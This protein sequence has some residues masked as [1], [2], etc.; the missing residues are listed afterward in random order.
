MLLLDDGKVCW[1]ATDLTRAV[2]CEYALVRGIDVRY[3][4][5]ETVSAP[6]LSQGHLARLGDLHEKQVLSKYEATVS[7]VTFE[8]LQSPLSLVRPEL[9]AF[10]G[11]SG[12]M[13]SAQS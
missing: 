11:L 8:P 3:G 10:I 4:A 7:V 1:S 13:G 12:S 9:G 5:P 2:E 6:D